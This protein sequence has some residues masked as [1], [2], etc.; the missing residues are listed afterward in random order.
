MIPRVDNISAGA[1]E[2]LLMLVADNRLAKV[3][4]GPMLG[5]RAFFYLQRLPVGTVLNIAERQP[6]TTG[7]INFNGTQIDVNKFLQEGRVYIRMGDSLYTIDG[8]KVE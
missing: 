5:L 8:Q 3:S 1:D 7:L 2:V 6:I 4:K